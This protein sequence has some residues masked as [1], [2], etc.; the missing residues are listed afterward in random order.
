MTERPAQQSPD[1]DPTLADPLYPPDFGQQEVSNRLG[2]EAAGLER[3]V[4]TW[5]WVVTVVVLAITAAALLIGA[6]R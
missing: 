3:P 6:P 1:W 4:L 5:F 2:R